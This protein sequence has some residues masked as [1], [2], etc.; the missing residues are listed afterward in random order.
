MPT[1]SLQVLVQDQGLIAKTKVK[2]DIQSFTYSESQKA[3]ADSKIF[4]AKTFRI[5]CVNRVYFQIRNKC[6]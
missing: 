4:Y 5:K 2:T 6:A 3:K 1:P